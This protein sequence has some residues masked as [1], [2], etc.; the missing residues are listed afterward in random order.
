MGAKIS[1][2][3]KQKFAES[4]GYKLISDVGPDKKLTILCFKHGEFR[5]S[6]SNFKYRNSGCPACKAE[7][8][9]LQKVPYETLIELA[10]KNQFIVH[11]TKEEYERS[12]SKKLRIDVTC[13]CGHRHKKTS[14]NVRNSTGCFKC[15]WR[16]GHPRQ[17]SRDAYL[18]K[19]KELGYI[20]KD[21]DSIKNTKTKFIAICPKHGE[22]ETTY[23]T[24]D[25]GHKCYRCSSF[26][27][28]GESELSLF[29]EALGLP[30]E[31]N[32][33]TILN[34]QE[35]DIYIP[36]K[37]VAIE[38]CGLYWHSEEKKGKYY[39]KAKHDLCL[40]K[41]IQLITI[42]EDEWLERQEQV[43]TILKAKLNLLP[44]IYARKT[45]V[46]VLDKRT[47]IDFLNK[48]HLQGACNFIIALGLE[49]EGQIVAC[50]TIS[51]HHRPNRSEAVLSRV[52]FADKAI[53]GGTSKL[54]KQLIVEAHK[55]GFSHL[56]SWSDN[57]WSSGKVYR[58][59][60]MTP[61]ELG[62]DYSYFKD[63]DQVRLSKQ[64]CQKKNLLKKG[65]IGNTELEMAKSLGYFRIW[66]CGKVKWSLKL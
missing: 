2:E 49:F 36:S 58:E 18:K 60:G 48:H 43:K 11:M 32:N 16:N 4:R 13:V 10:S 45:K 9:A 31:K 5:A 50:A 37:K 25:Q 62:A 33:R 42:F 41:G 12:H 65:A 26:G 17:L 34:G 47:A 61:E 57:R 24:L 64:S 3:N 23:N 30:I 35:L 21:I 66:D 54:L 6:W 20:I 19:A 7:K 59:L 39:H 63:G 8:S 15:R 38:Y 27:S 55:L 22:F 52:C 51:K 56:I 46:V 28:K 29:I 53:V 44:K 40:S 14:F 1:F